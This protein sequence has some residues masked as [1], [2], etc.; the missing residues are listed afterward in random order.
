MVLG[1]PYE[2]VIQPSKGARMIHRLRTA[3]IEGC[4]CNE[5]PLQPRIPH[6]AKPLRKW[7]SRIKAFFFRN[8][9]VWLT[10]LIDLS[11]GS[12]R[13]QLHPNNSVSK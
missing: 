8:A 12:I 2:R 3:T 7:E 11:Q 5:N 9:N 1:D 6:S 4:C 13:G 10:S